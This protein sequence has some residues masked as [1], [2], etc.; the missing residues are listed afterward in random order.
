MVGQ[1]DGQE[2]PMNRFSRTFACLIALVL[3]SLPLAAAE[4]IHNTLAREHISLDGEWHYI[5]DPYENGFYNHR[6]Q[7]H[8]NGYFKNAKKKNPTDLIEYDFAASPRL[9]VPGD[10]NTQETE[11]FWYEG[12]IWY[13]RDFKLNKKSHHQYVLHFGA[14]NYHAIVYVNGEKLGEHE[15]G[16]TPFQFDATDKLHQGD[17]FVVV[18]VSNRRERDQIPTVNTDWWNYGGIT[19]SV[20]LLELPEAHV[21]DYALYLNPENTGEILGWVAVSQTAR[22]AEVQLDIPELGVKQSIALKG[23][24]RVPF[25]IQAKPELWSPQNPR[26]YDINWRYQKNSVSDRVGFRQISV[27]GEDILL[28][29]QSIF[30]KGISIHEESPL[31][32]GR[33]WSQEDAR[34]LL[35]MAKDLGCNFV[36]LAH[37]PHNEHMLR[38]ADEMGLLVWSEIPV[39]WTVLFDQPSVYAKAEQQLVEMISRDKNRASIILWSV[40]N[41]TPLSQARLDFLQ[42]LITKARELDSSRLLTAALDTSSENEKGKII[43]D[44]L[45]AYVDVIGINNYCGWYSR[46]PAECAKLAWQSNY[47]KP[48]IMSEFGGGALAGWHSDQG[49]RWSE[50]YLVEVY[51]NN[52]AMID[53]ISFL[54]GMSPW[55]LKDFRSPR[56]PLPV[57]KDNWNRKGLVSDKGVRKQAWYILRD[58]YTNKP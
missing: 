17:N 36:R 3:F 20:R 33:A 45:S 44:P 26:L 35:Q 24:A 54:R 22:N 23:Q 2:T 48:I 38:M 30:L 6:Y 39:Y 7:E 5:I 37:Y 41:E 27:K 16:F 4:L 31:H 51:R 8:P 47:N 18:K 43:D 29:G 53:N 13:Q 34:A 25:R 56:R 50:E 12:T 11:L 46:T 55:V 40:A 9:K 21:A 14:V 15:G 32:P 58:Y 42:R 19:R 49:D 1:L 10:W 52:L 28:N 57:I